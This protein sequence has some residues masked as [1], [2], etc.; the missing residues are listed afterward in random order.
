MIQTGE[1][2]NDGN[3]IWTNIEPLVDMGSLDLLS[4]IL[5]CPLTH[6]K[7]WVK[8]DFKHN[9]VTTEEKEKK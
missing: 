4:I 3:A 8:E 1:A 5:D 2:R 9:I 6:N 7:I